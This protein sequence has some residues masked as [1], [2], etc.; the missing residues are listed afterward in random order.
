MR[1]SSSLCGNAVGKRLP[2]GQTGSLYTTG[3]PICAA[4]QLADTLGKTA[5][6]MGHGFSDGDPDAFATPLPEML[7]PVPWLSPGYAQVKQAELDAFMAQ[8][9]TR[10]FDWYL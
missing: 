6:P 8:A 7:A 1:S 4:M 5:D 3:T 9:F 2:L 10:E